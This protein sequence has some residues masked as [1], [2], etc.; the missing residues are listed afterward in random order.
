[1]TT[2]SLRKILIYGAGNVGCYLGG[3]LASAADAAP[4]ADANHA[5]PSVRYLV[6]AQRLAALREHGITLSDGDGYSRQ[7]AG[8]TLDLETDPAAALADIDL[9]LVTV[10]SAATAEVAAELAKH[11]PPKAVVISFQNG[12]HNAEPL[13]AALPDHTVLAGMVPFNIVQHA[14]D[15]FHQATSGHLMVE[16]SRWSRSLIDLFALAGLPLQDHPDMPAVQRAKLLLNLNNAINALSD[17]PLRD[18]LAQRVWRRC[19]ALAQREALQVFAAARLSL[20]KIT[21]LPPHWL[22][23]VLELPDLPFRLIASRMLAIDPHAR[24]SMWEDLRAG[25]RSEVDALQG[26][27]VAIAVAHGM[28]AP[29]N[30]RLLERIR[31]AEQQRQ[32]LTGATLLADLRAIAVERRT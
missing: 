6:R 13:R 2:E 30:A 18:E 1:M 19:L 12:L 27:I 10:K 4:V 7:L 15:T 5:Q 23:R 17:L 22:P 3:R 29:V 24:S 31:A 11:L 32:P 20:A 14:P 28:T 16:A 21:P 8:A 9:V 26:E 25:R